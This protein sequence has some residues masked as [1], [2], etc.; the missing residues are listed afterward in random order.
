MAAS[1]WRWFLKTSQLCLNFLQDTNHPFRAPVPKLIYCQWALSVISL[2]IQHYTLHFTNKVMFWNQS[3]NK[4]S[5]LEINF[6]CCEMLCIKNQCIIKIMLT[7]RPWCINPFH[8]CRCRQGTYRFY[9]VWRQTI[10]LCL[11]PDDFTS[12]WGNPLAVKGLFYIIIKLKLFQLCF[13]SFTCAENELFH[14]PQHFQNKSLWPT[15]SKRVF[16]QKLAV[17]SLTWRD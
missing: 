11:M 9:S 6:D 16:G 4:N 2:S 14:N 17:F 8:C 7:I 12:Q 5:N 10:L 3:F 15:E 1:W 13:A